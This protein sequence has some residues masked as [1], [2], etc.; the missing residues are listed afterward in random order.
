[1]SIPNLGL[2]EKQLSFLTYFKKQKTNVFS[3]RPEVFRSQKQRLTESVKLIGQLD[4]AWNSLSRETAEFNTDFPSFSEQALSQA[5]LH[6]HNWSQTKRTLDQVAAE[7]SKT[8]L[9]ERIRNDVSGCSNRMKQAEKYLGGVKEYLELCAI[10]RDIM[11]EYHATK[12]N[13]QTVENINNR[14]QKLSLEIRNFLKDSHRRMLEEMMGKVEIL[15][16]FNKSMAS[17]EESYSRLTQ[18]V[19]SGTLVFAYKA[20]ASIKKDMAPVSGWLAEFKKLENWVNGQSEENRGLLVGA[21]C[22]AQSNRRGEYQ[23]YIT[24]AAKMKALVEESGYFYRAADICAS[25]EAMG[26][27]MYRKKQDVD[28]L[29]R[30]YNDL[31]ARVSKHIDAA[32]VAKLNSMLDSQD[33]MAQVDDMIADL[34]RERTKCNIALS[35]GKLNYSFAKYDFLREETEKAAEWMTK[36]ES[37][38]Q[39]LKMLQGKLE[40]QPAKEQKISSFKAHAAKLED[41]LA[42]MTKVTRAYEFELP[43]VN[44]NITLAT[45]DSLLNEYR[46]AYEK[47][48]ADVK[49]YVTPK[50]GSLLNQYVSFRRDQQNLVKQVA[51]LEKE[52]ESL[53]KQ[54]KEP[55]YDTHNSLVYI[56]G[57][58]ERLSGLM[59]TLKEDF[60]KFKKDYNCTEGISMSALEG[61]SQKLKERRRQV[62]ELRRCKPLYDWAKS[63]EK[64]PMR[65]SDEELSKQ[66]AIFLSEQ[67]R[68]LKFDSKQELVDIFNKVT[69]ELQARAKVQKKR[70]KKTHTK[71]TVT[72]ILTLLLAAVAVGAIVFVVLKN[73][74]YVQRGEYWKWFGITA[75]VSVFSAVVLGFTSRRKEVGL[76]FGTLCAL[77]LVGYSL[78]FYLKGL[79]SAFW[80]LPWII[81]GVLISLI[82]CAICDQEVSYV[83]VCIFLAAAAIFL[84]GIVIWMICV[85]WRNNDFNESTFFGQIGNFFIGAWALLSGLIS[86][87]FKAILFVFGG[88]F[89]YR[90]A[91]VIDAVLNAI[92][93]C[94]MGGALGSFIIAA[95]KEM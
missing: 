31:D 76:I 22:V 3:P 24:A 84:V 6:I 5:A 44:Q 14:Y 18:P 1:M 88:G 56:P 53:E 75:A 86:G 83:F 71:K 82:I 33:K 66:Y 45:E 37:L 4:A 17:L 40:I 35:G 65:C 25:I 87:L 50:W 62:E 72:T 68:Y 12:P 81:L 47:L 73:G 43:L 54:W 70:E 85:V 58:E 55:S 7:A 79:E 48:P 41:V 91:E 64:L 19:R 29:W 36:Y 80:F 27:N 13:Y 42:E 2:S 90:Q 46:K 60:S 94:L 15:H 28:K 21:G 52:Y 34:D 20:L 8:Y 38:R 32:M 69:V 39:V 67:N 78:P 30:T 26:Q 11:A 92:L 77:Y 61:Y 74:D 23:T 16:R 95:V 89:W 9:P 93:F 49:A 10:E 57:Q 51:D 59:A 63:F